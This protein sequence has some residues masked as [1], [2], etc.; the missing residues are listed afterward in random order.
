MHP[1]VGS[2][3]RWILGW[4]SM[5]A[6]VAAAVSGL[7]GGRVAAA[8]AVVGGGIGVLAGAAY[9]WRALRHSEGEAGSLYRAQVLGEGYK[10]AA[11][12]GLFA[13]VFVVW[14]DVPALPLFLAYILTFGV[15]WVALLQKR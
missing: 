8:A 13:L 6:L 14:R 5:L 11:T 12:L 15:Y 4:Q 3:V 7:V 10:F 9:V 1:Q 2:Q